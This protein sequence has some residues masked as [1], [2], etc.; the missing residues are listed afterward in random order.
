MTVC[1]I[2]AFA[3]AVV[4]LSS[5]GSSGNLRTGVA[6]SVLGV[7]ADRVAGDPVASAL[8]D[9]IS[10]DD[11]GR[12]TGADKFQTVLLE[13]TFDV[14][15]LLASVGLLGGVEE[16]FPGLTELWLTHPVWEARK[17]ESDAVLLIA[18]GF[19]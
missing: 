4:L 17:D 5:V 16:I 9:E 6:F 19:A 11:F 12:K 10:G 13:L 15:V 18:L 8:F 3:A 1:H 2:L 14:D 7:D